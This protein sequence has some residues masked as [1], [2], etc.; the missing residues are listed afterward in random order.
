MYVCIC[1]GIKGRDVEA[2]LAEGVRRP[3]ELHRHF[4]VEPQCGRCMATIR[5]MVGDRRSDGASPARRKSC[6][7][8]CGGC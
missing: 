1:H 8:G 4:G 2:A 5:D 7:G 3:A 6:G